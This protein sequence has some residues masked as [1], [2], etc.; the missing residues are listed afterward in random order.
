MDCVGATFLFAY[1]SAGGLALLNAYPILRS[2]KKLSF[3]NRF[4]L[5]FSF[6]LPLFWL[7]LLLNSFAPLIALNGAQI[8][9]FLVSGNV[10]V[11]FLQVLWRFS[12]LTPDGSKNEIDSF[13]FHKDDL[14]IDSFDVVGLKEAHS[15]DFRGNQDAE[16]TNNSSK[17]DASESGNGLEEQTL[18]REREE[19]WIAPDDQAGPNPKATRIYASFEDSPH[20]SPPPV[21][22][23]AFPEEGMPA[24]RFPDADHT[25]EMEV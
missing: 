16:T 9:G 10:Y 5:T 17:K 19:L 3:R 7:L 15:A 6:G 20:R 2:W 11:F 18:E 13:A 23:Q 4:I 8:I 24:I 25:K 12:R 22:Y 1:C 14:K 21:G